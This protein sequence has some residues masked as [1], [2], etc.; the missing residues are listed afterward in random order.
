MVAAGKSPT[1]LSFYNFTVIIPAEKLMN[2][3]IKVVVVGVGSWGKNLLREFDLQSQV[4]YACHNGSSKSRTEVGKYPH[5]RST[6]N[7]YEALNDRSV[8]AVVIATPT[9]THRKI[10][11]QALKAGKH[12]FLEKPGGASYEEL[13]EIATEADRRELKMA[14]GYEFVFH[15]ALQWLKKR[16]SPEDILEL[17][18]LWAKLGT[19]QDHPIPHLVSHAVSIAMGL[20][21]KKFSPAQTRVYGAISKPDIVHSE[22][23]LE[24]EVNFEIHIDRVVPGVK[25]RNLKIITR[26]GGYIWQDDDLFQ[27]TTGNEKLKEVK[28][29]SVTAVQAEVSDFLD[30][31]REERKPLVDDRFGLD[32]WRVI[33]KIQNF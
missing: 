3:K 30:A 28:L 29:P 21:F 22:L 19:F 1:P 5:I 32:V 18:F 23:L 13:E 11:L 24:N 15:A 31:I 6:T 33:E 27:F 10:A 9:P 2:Q 8:E 16:L 4:V 26:D 12:I 14:L 7:L 17:H 20:G 25:C